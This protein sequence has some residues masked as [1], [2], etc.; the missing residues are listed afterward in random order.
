MVSKENIF[1]DETQT[2]DS[3]LTPINIRRKKQK[4]EAEKQEALANEVLLTVKDHFRKP[5]IK[6][7]RFD[8]SGKTVAMK[9]RDLPKDQMLS[10]DRII[11]DTLFLAEMGSLTLNHR[12][13]NTATEIAYHSPIS[14]IITSSGTPSPILQQSTIENQE[15]YNFQ[16]SIPQD[17][18]QHN[19]VSDLFKNFN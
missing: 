19:S 8:M 11:N 5:V 7:D 1:H 14:S 16:Q 9:L 18:T 13:V 17:E 2:S 10:A 15:Y 12:V 4:I 3:E 6:E